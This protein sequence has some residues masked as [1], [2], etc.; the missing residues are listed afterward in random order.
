MMRVIRAL[1]GCSRRDAQAACDVERDRAEQEVAMKAVQMKVDALQAGADQRVK[2]GRKTEEAAA[3]L[4]LL[5]KLRED[6]P[7]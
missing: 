4:V 1:L 2:E 6:F 7:Q 5:A 3:A